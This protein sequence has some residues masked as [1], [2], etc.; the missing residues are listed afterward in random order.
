MVSFL[1]RT[2]I[3]EVRC[4]VTDTHTDIPNY[5][6]A[7]K[8]TV[9]EDIVPGHTIWSFDKTN[10]HTGN[11]GNSLLIATLSH[12][13]HFAKDGMISVCFDLRQSPACDP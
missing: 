9:D 13:R 6:K 10:G 7:R 3:R 1:G 4:R 2:D 11:Q 5:C 8:E 12:G